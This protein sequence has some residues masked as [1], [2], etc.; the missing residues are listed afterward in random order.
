MET[1]PRFIVSSDSLGERTIEPATLE[2]KDQHSNQ[3]ATAYVAE[4]NA[5]AS[6]CIDLRQ[7]YLL[8]S[9]EL[10]SETDKADI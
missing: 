7:S 4:C 8:T 2:W 5:R 3:C 10:F 9:L 6:V 1:G